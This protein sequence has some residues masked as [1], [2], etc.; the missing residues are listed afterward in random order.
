[1]VALSQVRVSVNPSG[2]HG[3][4]QTVIGRFKITVEAVTWP[5]GKPGAGSPT[6]PRR[7]LALERHRGWDRL[8]VLRD[9]NPNS[10]GR[11]LR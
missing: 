3:A 9:V 6:Q 8:S 10:P 5:S 7:R 4:I 2:K 1:M 11:W